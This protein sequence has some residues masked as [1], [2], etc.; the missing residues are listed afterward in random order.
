[1]SESKAGGNSSNLKP[2]RTKSEARERGR[3]GGLKSGEVR[4]ARI[5]LKE[6]LIAILEL[7]GDDGAANQKKM[8]IAIAEQALKGNIRAYEVIRDT[9]GERPIDRVETNLVGD[10]AT[11]II[12][13][14]NEDTS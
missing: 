2:V 11:I 4:R 9:I 14:D 3:K 1:M 6:E 13:I 7:V 12:E 10:N 5:S 8:S